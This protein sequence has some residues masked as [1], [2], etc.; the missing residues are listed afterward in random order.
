MDR[1][2]LTTTQAALCAARGENKPIPDREPLFGD[3]GVAPWPPV[4]VGGPTGEGG[5][6]SIVLE[7]VD[8]VVEGGM[9]KS[10]PAG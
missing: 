2:R 6:G 5:G 10:E 8:V 4:V 9:L 3:F 7:G 1:H